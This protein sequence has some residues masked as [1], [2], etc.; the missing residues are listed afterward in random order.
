[1]QKA[2]DRSAPRGA[3]DVTMTVE[4]LMVLGAERRDD[5]MSA[6]LT[7]PQVLAEPARSY[8][9]MAAHN[10]FTGNLPVTRAAAQSEDSRDL[11]GF[12]K[13]TTVSNL[14]GRRWEA[15][16][17]DQSKKDGE[18]RLRTTAGFNEFSYT[19]RYD[20]VLVKGVVI[21]IDETGVLF[22]AQ[23]RFY[24]IGLGDSLYDVMREPLES[25]SPAAG[26]ALGAFWAASW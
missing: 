12:V 4:A 10:I 26:A 13:L 6:S 24:R 25:P 23:G 7:R 15:W 8:I 21:R 14:N 17:F 16:L 18:S 2:Q 5:L 20:N 1:V 22:K 3:L 11:L 9:E 19:D